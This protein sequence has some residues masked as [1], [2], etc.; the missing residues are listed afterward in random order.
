MAI[1]RLGIVAADKLHL[2]VAL[3]GLT[4]IDRALL[5]LYGG[6][7]PPLY[8]SGVVYKPEHPDEWESLDILLA[9]GSGDCED[10]AAWRAAELQEQGVQAFA[11]VYNVRANKW[12]AIVRLP[13]GST[14]DPSKVLG[15]NRY[16]RRRA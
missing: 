16:V 4:A 7:V 2:Q 5:K 10:L 9:R 14:E 13:D 3:A 15:M 11:T 6:E 1:I 12:H 8:Q